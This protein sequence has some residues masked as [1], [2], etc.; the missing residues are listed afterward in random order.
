ML[1]DL[2]LTPMLAMFSF[3]AL[4]CISGWLASQP[5]HAAALLL[6]LVVLD[7]LNLPIEFKFGIS[8]YPADLV[9]LV[10]TVACLIRFSLFA[11]P[12]VVPAAWWLIG[13]VQL[14]L[15]IW[16]VKT[17]GTLAGVD[18]RGHYYLWVTVAYFCSVKWSDRMIAKVMNLWILCSI[19]LC[20]L[21]Y[22]RWI[23]SALDPKYEQEIMA[24]DTTGVRFRVIGSVSTL[25]IAIG[26]L[27]LLFRA[28]RGKLVPSLWLV[29]PLELAAIAILQHRSVWV[30]TF[31]GTACLLW[32]K[33][34]GGGK[35]RSA[36]PVLALVLIPLAIAVAIPTKDNSVLASVKSSA[37]HAVSLEEGTMVGRAQ[38]WNELL[39]R[40]IDS[41]DPTTYLV[42]FPYGSG[43]NPIDFGDGTGQDMV[44]HNHFVHVLYRG[45]IIGLLATLSILWRTWWAAVNHRKRGDK[46]WARFFFAILPALF[47]YFIPYWATYESGLLLGIA[48]SYLGVERRVNLSISYTA[49]VA[50]FAPRR[51]PPPY[52]PVLRYQFRSRLPPE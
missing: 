38:Y 19:C 51:L 42:G 39:T 29:F 44:P 41:R 52:R 47:A 40:W 12:R 46:P 20:L 22:Y 6:G 32:A 17:I 35:Q 37:D 10:L 34:G 2:F 36:I 1:H 25:V 27:G 9:F 8:L 33:P 28:I 3:M 14:G 31:V 26:A 24:F 45:G 11:S 5:T 30:S 13:L 4:A 23:N 49:S 48:I 43:Y 18:A 21:V 50:R 15:A 16:G 7:A